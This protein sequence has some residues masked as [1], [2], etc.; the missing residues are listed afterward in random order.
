MNIN[1]ILKNQPVSCRY[2]A[3]MGQRSGFDDAAPL[4]LQ[5]VR[6]DSQ[7]YAPDGTYWGLGTPLWCAFNDGS[8]IWVRAWP[9]ADAMIE[10]RDYAP[11]ATFKR[12]APC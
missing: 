8:R 11:R 7:G 2:G 9:R 5:K 3:P 4:Y 10:V 6:I 12:G 1:A